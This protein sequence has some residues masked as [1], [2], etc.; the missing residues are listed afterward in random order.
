[1]YH[2]LS[3]L[4][5]LAASENKPVWQIV[6]EAEVKDF[7]RNEA[8]I[9]E[10]LKRRMQVMENAAR[11]ALNKPYPTVGNLITGMAMTQ[12]HYADEKNTVCGDMINRTMAMALSS[13]EVNGS[14]GKIC[15][16][17]TAGSCGILPAVL[18]SV[19]E[20]LKAPQEEVLRALLVASGIGAVITENATVS[21]SEGGVRGGSSD[22]SG[23][24]CVSKGRQPGND[25]QRLWIFFDELYGTCVR[26][27]GGTCADAVC[28]KK[29]VSG[30]QCPDQRRHGT[31][32]NGHSCPSR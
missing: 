1:M 31:E 16:A 4:C 3:D 25:D 10:E 22:G 6:L 8:E 26:S 5:Q 30:G 7:G 28:R 11:K 12:N 9:F 29:C 20:Q 14:M 24:S 15:A 21:G 17:P 19:S 23:G 32:R 13:C 2:S 27:G 18:I